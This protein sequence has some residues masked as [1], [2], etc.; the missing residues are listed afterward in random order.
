MFVVLRQSIF[1]E[2]QNHPR[3]LVCGQR[4][5]CG[6][7]RRCLRLDRSGNR[8]HKFR[9]DVTPTGRS[10][11]S[12]PITYC[13]NVFSIERSTTS[14]KQNALMLFILRRQLGLI[15]ADTASGSLLI[16]R[17]SQ[18]PAVTHF[19]QKSFINCLFK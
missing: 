14:E 5:G 13:C 1:N 11:D 4:S 3:S 8:T 9:T 6:G 17:L 19:Y 7:E 18:I 2:W 10:R 12:R 15:K 16:F